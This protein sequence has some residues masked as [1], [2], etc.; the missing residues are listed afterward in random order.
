MPMSV[1]YFMA[2]IVKIGVLSE[3]S[4]SHHHRESSVYGTYIK[5]IF[6]HNLHWTALQFSDFFCDN[7][8]PD[9]RDVKP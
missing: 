6:T 8:S 2:I 5:T 9:E 3:Y 7:Q 1:H 4:V